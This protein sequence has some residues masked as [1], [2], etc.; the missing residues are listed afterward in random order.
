MLDNVEQVVAARPTSP[1]L[2]TSCP[3]LT[4]LVT[5]RETLRVEGEHE[6][7]VPP[8]AVPDPT[9]PISLTELASARR[10]RSS[11]NGPGRCSRTSS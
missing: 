7:P 8:L 10:S 11:C 9:R 5:S 6:F 3:G 2:L 4:L 1:S